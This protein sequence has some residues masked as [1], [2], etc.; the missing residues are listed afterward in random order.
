MRRTLYRLIVG[1]IGVA[2]RSG[3]SK[4]LEIIVLRHQLAV[5]RRQ[6]PRPTI[7]DDDR[8]LLGAIVQALPRQ[9]RTG[10]RRR[11]HRRCRTPTE[12]LDYLLI[13]GLP[14][15]APIAHHGPFVMNTRDEILQAIE[16]YQ[17]GRLGHVPA[18]E[19]NPRNVR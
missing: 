18:E 3:R 8:T 14:I 15:R 9:L 16:D 6:S 13:G 10:R 11:A 7:D 5:L 1:L 4:D 12:S 17:A 2:V 19:L